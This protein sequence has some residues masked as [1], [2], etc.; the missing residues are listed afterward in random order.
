MTGVQ[1]GWELTSTSRVPI[2][3]IIYLIIYSNCFLQNCLIVQFRGVGTASRRC[4]KN[5]GEEKKL[6]GETRQSSLK[7][8]RCTAINSINNNY[9]VVA[10]IE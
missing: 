4:R 5:T 9:R 7:V 1:S 10:D 3:L 6:V 2:P 8:D